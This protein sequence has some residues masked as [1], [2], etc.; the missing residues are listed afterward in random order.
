MSR[1]EYFPLFPSLGEEATCRLGRHSCQLFLE[2]YVPPRE[3][4]HFFLPKAGSQKKLE[5]QKIMGLAGCEKQ[6]Q[7]FGAIGLG[8]AF[9]VARP[10]S[11]PQESVAAMS[12]EHLLNHHH[13][14]ADRPRR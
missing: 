10:V 3:E 8:N 1:K 6:L 5:Q 11:A 13:F 4:L 7:L 14:G 2:A 9:H 12:F